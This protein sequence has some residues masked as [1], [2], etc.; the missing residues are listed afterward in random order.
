MDWSGIATDEETTELFRAIT[1]RDCILHDNG[2]SGI[3]LA[4]VDGF[5]IENVEAHDNAYY[6][7]D[8]TSSKDGELSSANGVVRHSSFYNHTG[9]EGHGLAILFPLCWLYG[10][11]K[12]S[13]APE[14][15]WRFL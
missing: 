8:I 14:S 9:D 15:V 3:D 7:L 4:V 1:I 6:G 13:R 10:R 11:F 2:R 12:N 5:V